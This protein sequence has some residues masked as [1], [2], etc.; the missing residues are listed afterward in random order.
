MPRKIPTVLTWLDIRE[1]CSF[2]SA[3]TFRSNL[4]GPVKRK[5]FFMPDGTELCLCLEDGRFLHYRFEGHFLLW[6]DGEEFHEEKYECFRLREDVTFLH[7]LRTAES[8]Y[9][10]ATLILDGSS[11]SVTFVEMNLGTVYAN[12]EVARTI[13]FGTFTFGEKPDKAASVCAHHLTDRLTGVVIDWKYSPSARIH[14]MYEN[15]TCCAFVSPV[16]EDIPEW[17][18]FFTTFN[19]SQ[20]VEFGRNLWLVSFC[21]LGQSGVTVNQL[22]DLSDMTCV[23]SFFGIDSSDRLRSYTY[24]GVG[25]F[26]DVAFVG[27]Y[28]IE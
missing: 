15:R 28:A 10:A 4:D 3:S 13:H 18:D 17:A 16:P 23:G 25:A 27:E 11:S 22:M 14:E 7:H 1:L 26:A 8:P 24:G 6:S 2:P 9:S 5:P 12:R 20:Y 21:A 19:P